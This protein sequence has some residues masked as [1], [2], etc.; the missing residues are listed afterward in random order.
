MTPDRPVPV[1]TRSLMPLPDEALSG[2]LLRL[3]HRL[4]L[5]P[6]RIARLTG[7]IPIGPRGLIP[8]GH[9][10]AMEPLT[11]NRFAQATALT[12]TEAA[13]L[14]LAG[15]RDRYP[16]LKGVGQGQSRTLWPSWTLQTSS[17]YCPQCLAGDGT[18]IQNL[19]GGPWRRTWRLSI[20]FACPQ[21]RRFLSTTCPT[22]SRPA[23]HR[24]EH[25]SLIPRERVILHPAQ[26][27]SILAAPSRRRQQLCEARLDNPA[28]SSEEQEVDGQLLALQQRILDMLDPNSPATTT[29]LGQTTPVARYFADLRLLTTLIQMSWSRAR[30]VAVSI[31]PVDALE[32]SIG[33]RTA[34]AGQ[35][36]EPGAA[37]GRRPSLLF[38]LPADVHAVA[39]LLVVADSI[40]ISTPATAL[41]LLRPMIDAAAHDRTWKAQWTQQQSGCSPALAQLVAPEIAQASRGADRR[42]IIGKPGPVRPTDSIQAG[43]SCKFDHRH[44][45]Q[46]LETTWFKARLSSL[47]SGETACINPVHLKRTIAI[48][49]V[50]IS[51][52]IA[53]KGG[54]QLLGCPYSRAQSSRVQVLRWLEDHPDHRDRYQTAVETLIEGLNGA[55]RL[56]D[57]GRRRRVLSDW[58][59]SLGDWNRILDARP[60]PGFTE[61]ISND[62]ALV[63]E[64]SR[65]AASAFIWARA[66]GGEARLA[67]AVATDTADPL[68]R[69]MVGR[70]MSV[71]TFKAKQGGP[72]ILA[73]QETLDNFTTKLTLHIDA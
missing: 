3:S 50:E 4:G 11:L 2:F 69:A 58:S 70:A 42:R 30:E 59:L 31:T 23:L 67:P 17:R 48:R 26:C 20:A 6:R 65:L 10:L 45:P 55:S 56:I 60:L 18:V 43:L 19:H 25:E 44:I 21:H 16:P 49:L 63:G 72:G 73:F 47:T 38:Q 61:G 37:T 35:V 28:S 64:V 51:E 62:R 1:L 27:R 52:R 39:P 14:T 57:Y 33:H 53:P 54:A 46:Y 13:R 22:C 66:T 36:V 32:A 12:P 5:S 68:R 29:V 41:S 15:L 71:F 34:D 7:L 24:P 8:L 40:L 9:L